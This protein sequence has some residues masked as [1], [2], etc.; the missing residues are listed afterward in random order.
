MGAPQARVQLTGDRLGLEWPAL[1]SCT[2]LTVRCWLRDGTVHESPRW[3]AVPAIANRFETRCGP[4]DV[5]VELQPGDGCVRLRA[6]A[7]ATRDVDVARVAVAVRLHG[8]DDDLAWVLT[9]G[10]QSWDPSGCLPAS[11]ATRESWWTVA[12]A[13]AGGAGLAAAAAGARSCCTQFTIADGVL[14]VIWREAET[15]E[16]LPALFAGSTGTRWRSES[17]LLAAG[18]DVRASMGA[19][20]GGP[21]RAAPATVGW[22]T[23][24]H[25]GPWVHRE[26]VLAHADILASEPFRALG[27]RL[28]Q[29]DDGWQET[30]G[31]WRPNTKFPGGLPALSEELGRRGQ[32]PGLW[33]APFLVGVAADL[34]ET[35]P[36]D[37]FVRDPI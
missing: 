37:W 25:L 14:S 9:N 13:G 18:Q 4:L 11:G 23:W 27:Y 17:V 12:V 30:Y 6:E 5:N 33:T 8:H 32:V 34:A 16:S 26:D 15:L 3:A 19:V 10:Y 1:A 28:V 36:D 20:L 7:L 35:A 31:E 2:D 24:Y 29:L 21:G 22:L